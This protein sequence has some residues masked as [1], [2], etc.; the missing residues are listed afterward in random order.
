MSARKIH[1]LGNGRLEEAVA[2]A[3]LY[4]GHLL[5][6]DSAGKVK[7]HA[8]ADGYAERM[9]AVEDSLQGSTIATAYAAADQ[10]RIVICT[11]GD[12]VQAY[13]ASG[14]TVVIGDQLCS[15]GDG[16]LKKVTGS[17]VPIA[18]AMEAQDLSDTGDSDTLTRVRVL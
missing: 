16:T 12:V 17:E 6:M 4:P 11:P 18:V 13:L 14:E 9:F 7:K 3:E 10:V 15:N 8:T 5:V 2:A 1:L